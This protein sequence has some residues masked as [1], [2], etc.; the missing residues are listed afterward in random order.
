M[1]QGW[2]R[3][4]IPVEDF[5]PSFLRP[6]KHKRVISES[7]SPSGDCTDAYRGTIEHFLTWSMH[8]ATP[9]REE[10][11]GGDWSDE[12][13]CNIARNSRSWLATGVAARSIRV[14]HCV[15]IVVPAFPGLE[16]AGP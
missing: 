2:I 12:I 10:N 3:V 7:D 1:Y 6:T 11:P 13:K 9:S 5:P 15:R 4:S 8:D 14:T 16:A